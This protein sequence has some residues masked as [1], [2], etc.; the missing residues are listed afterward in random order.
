VHNGA[1]V[2]ADLTVVFLHQLFGPS[3]A[4]LYLQDYLSHLRATV[5]LVETHYVD[6][7]FLDDFTHYYARSFRPPTPWCARVHFFRTHS[8]IGLKEIFGRAYASVSALQEVESILNDV[9]LGFV[10]KRPLIGAPIGRTVLRT[11]PVEGRRHYTVVR[12][13]DVHVAGV[14]LS[15]K[16]LA[17]QQQDRGAAVCASTSLWSALQRVARVAGHRTPTPSAITRAAASPFPASDGL[18]ESRM[19]ASLSSLGY[20]ADRFAPMENRPLFRALVVSCLE[21]QLPV[22]LL[23]MRKQRTGAGEIPVGHA[24]CVT[25]FSE[26]PATTDV[27]A[28]QVGRAPIRMKGGAVEI[29]YVH[30]DNLGSHAHYEIFDNADPTDLL[31]GFEK[32]MLRRGRSGAGSAPPDPS[33]AVDPAAPAPIPPGPDN[34][35]PPDEW[36]IFGA[37]VPKPDK[38]RLPV[39]QL[40][41]DVV[42]LRLLVERMFVG[43]PF[44]YSPRFATGIEYKRSLF[45]ATVDREDLPAFMQVPLPRYIGVISTYLAN[46]LIFDIV[47]DVSEVERDPTR[48]PVIA[49]VAPGIAKN[50]PAWKVLSAVATALSWPLIT[51]P[52]GTTPIATALPTPP[53]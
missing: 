26:P 40:F 30:D 22:I 51:A 44:H 3:A 11:Y 41:Y 14:T 31:N 6:R 1:L 21:S 49:I 33:V 47:L 2:F 52:V 29:L 38:L 23:I 27:P 8:A 50:S 10:V 39:K 15:V 7:H 35:W 28:T 46:T 5:V 45:D 12:N 17:Y 37:L 13:Y 16:G 36:A 53:P 18:D 25:G 34:W 48:P 43:F 4:T 42:E 9:Y 32:L 19:A 20:I 24:V